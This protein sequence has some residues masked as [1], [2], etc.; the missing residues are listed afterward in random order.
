MANIYVFTGENAYLLQQERQ[1][2]IDEFAK[3]HGEDNLIRSTGEK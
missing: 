1:L 2:W 3:K